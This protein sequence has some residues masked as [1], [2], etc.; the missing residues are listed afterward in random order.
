M[1]FIKFEISSGLRVPHRFLPLQPT[2][3]KM[4]TQY[5]VADI[6][7]ASFGRREM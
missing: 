3:T 6:S 4:A 2:L 7:L 5:K 1:H